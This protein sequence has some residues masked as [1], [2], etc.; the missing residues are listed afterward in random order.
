MAGRGGMLAWFRGK[1]FFIA[2]NYYDFGKE[3]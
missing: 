2:A 3:P 1:R